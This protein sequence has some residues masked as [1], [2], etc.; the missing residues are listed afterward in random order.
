MPNVN[1]K[2]SLECL[3]LKAQYMDLADSN[4]IPPIMMKMCEY[5]MFK[6]AN[7]ASS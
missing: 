5:V 2:D 1:L 3:Y 7:A 6:K 4:H